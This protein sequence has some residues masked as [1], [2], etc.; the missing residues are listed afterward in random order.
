MDAR[1]NPA[2]DVFAVHHVHEGSRE[3]GSTGFSSAVV[4][5]L[6]LYNQVGT[7]GNIW[8]MR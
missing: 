3:W 4:N 8:L 2:G 7:A 1:G 5:G 6:F